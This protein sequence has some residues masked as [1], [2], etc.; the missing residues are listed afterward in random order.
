[1]SEY[2]HTL[3]ECAGRLEA[4]PFALGVLTRYRI[5]PKCCRLLIPQIPFGWYE[6][7]LYGGM[8][9][10]RSRRI[11]VWRD[12]DQICVDAMFQHSAITPAGT[13]KAVHGYSLEVSADAHS[14]NLT[15]VLAT[16][17]ILLFPECPS[18]VENTNRLIGVPLRE[19]RAAELEHL[20][21]TFGLNRYA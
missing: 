11:D 2:D 21:K 16:P 7:P 17:R 8:S 5:A 14:L 13:R 3:I 19:F 9:M 18:A 20:P 10:R 6:L 12:G 4:T 15:L 1:M